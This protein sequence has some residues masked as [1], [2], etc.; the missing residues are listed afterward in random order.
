M[1]N[2]RNILG[3][4]S[5]FMLTIVTTSCSRVAP[6]YQGV[7]MENFGKNG[8]QDFT[9]VKGRV[10]TMTPGTELF[11][12]PLFDQRAEFEQ[13]STLKAADNT[14]F[15]T[16]PLYSYRVVEDRAID[17]VFSNK[18]LSN[19]GDKFMR[20]LEDNVLEPKIE[21][22]MAEVSRSYTTDA[23]MEK[24]GSLMFEKAVEERV[25][26]EFDRRGLVL[27]SFRAQLEFSKKVTEKIDNRNEVDTNLSVIDKQIEEQKRKNELEQL[28]TEQLLIRSKGLTPQILEERAI[29]KWNG[30]RPLNEGTG[31]PFIINKK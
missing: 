28:K 1:K 3:L 9:L 17:V 24:G 13:H 6:N 16:R 8:K 23:L 11:Q 2:L 15:K 25:K 27:L 26:S 21:D 22:I 4:L 7:L 18:Q 10:N 29:E 20:S 30:V 14:E 5:I 12:V 19:N 31:S